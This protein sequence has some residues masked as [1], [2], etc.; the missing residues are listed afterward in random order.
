MLAVFHADGRELTT[1]AFAGP[2]L[3]AGAGM[4]MV[5]APLFNFILAGVDDHEVG[6]ASGTLN[7][8]QQLGGAIGI[9]ALGTL[10]FSTATDAGMLVAVERTLWC[11]AALLV[12]VAALTFLLPM[13]P[14]E[15]AAA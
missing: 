1:L 11:E 15:D 4:G 12:V 10:F 13:R 3:A 14:R 5:L 9:A 8:M 6:S 7:A 2:E